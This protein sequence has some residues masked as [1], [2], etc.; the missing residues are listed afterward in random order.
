MH[1]VIWST[2]SVAVCGH[3]SFGSVG[4]PTAPPPTHPPRA[5]RRRLLLYVENPMIWLKVGPWTQVGDRSPFICLMS[6]SSVCLSFSS[7]SC[8]IIRGGSEL[9]SSLSSIGRS[10]PTTKTWWELDSLFVWSPAESSFSPLTSCWF[11]RRSNQ[12]GCTLRWR[13][14][15]DANVPK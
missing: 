2:A 6:S 5:K 15:C 9:R 1:M 12:Y 14:T 7:H 8:S 10:T 11:Y 13:Q 4:N 3:W